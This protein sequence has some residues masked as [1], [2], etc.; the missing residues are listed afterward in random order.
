MVPRTALALAAFLVLPRDVVGEVSAAAASTSASVSAFASRF[1]DIELHDPRHRKQNAEDW[2]PIVYYSA[3]VEADS[4][5]VAAVAHPIKDHARGDTAGLTTTGTA[6][7][8]KYQPLG[9]GGGVFSFLETASSPD[10]QRLA[11]HRIECD[12]MFRKANPL[13]RPASAYHTGTVIE[14][15]NE[16]T[17][18]KLATLMENT[19][20]GNSKVEDHVPDI[21]S[22]GR[23]TKDNSGDAGVAK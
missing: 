5:V 17:K 20:A 19:R 2:V 3:Q 15:M 4:N 21:L 10:P 18:K 9:A 7:E 23:S 16:P 11:P 12:C 6:A 22:S 1:E 8:H 13:G 14:E